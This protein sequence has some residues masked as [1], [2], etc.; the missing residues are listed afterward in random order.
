MSRA[1]WIEEHK[2]SNDTKRRGT[3]ANEMQVNDAIVYPAAG[4]LV[5]AIEAAKQMVGVDEQIAA[6]LVKDVTFSSPLTVTTDAPG[7][8]TQVQLRPLADP[9]TKT[10]PYYSFHV[11]MCN[12]NVWTETC[13]GTVQVVLE[14]S[15]TQVDRG[16]EASAKLQDYRR[17]L[18]TGMRKCRKGMDR[19]SI[20]EYMLSTG[21]DYGPSFQAIQDVLHD[22]SGIACA[23]VNTPGTIAQEVAAAAQAHV[24]HPTTLDGLF[25]LILMALSKS[26]DTRMPTVMP[27]RI[28]RLWISGQGISKS[29]TASINAH[30]EAAFTG[31]RKAGGNMFALNADSSGILVSLEGTEMTA[32]TGNAGDTLNEGEK[33]RLAYKL[34]WKPDLDLLTSSQ[35]LAYCEKLRPQRPSDAEFY[36]TLGFLMIKFLSESLEALPTDHTWSADSHLHHYHS[37]AK[38]QVGRF[39]RSQ[40][41]FL[42]NNHPVWKRLNED[43]RYTDTLITDIKATTQGKFFLKIAEQL[44]SILKNEIDPLAFM[45]EDDSIPEFYREVNQKVIC[46]EPLERY[47]DLVSHKTPGLK[48]LEIGAGTGAT[49]DFIL[50]AL[51]ATNNDGDGCTLQCTQY[52]Y[53]DISPVFFDAAATRFQRYDSQMRFKVLDI[54]QDPAAQGFEMGSYDLIIAASV[55]G[56]HLIISRL[57]TILAQVLHAT[58]NLEVTMRN[59][60]A[61][62]KP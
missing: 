15:E 55:S 25:Q 41:P 1:H 40:M 58:K 45:F 28:G 30:A 10:S 38:R 59:T 32:V 7:T 6:Y 53:T 42:S 52:D 62:L 23:I 21:L 48:V 36:T 5:M 13:R 46:Y 19:K 20:Y 35:V 17:V 33:R 26:T 60:R 27:T 43:A 56:I 50:G 22:N 18:E 4:M 37:W 8:E 49:T 14:K 54:A 3:P 11:S 29:S 24:I 57:L 2:V 44:L 47:L 34:S 61:L 12:L 31:R 51:D 39:Q 16:R 9:S